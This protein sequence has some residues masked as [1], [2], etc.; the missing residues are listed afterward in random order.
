[1]QAYATTGRLPL[2]DRLRT[3][4]RTLLTSFRDASTAGDSEP[5][6]I[7]QILGRLADL[8]VNRLM[9]R[10]GRIPAITLASGCMPAARPPISASIAT[11]C[12]NRRSAC[13]PQP[14][15]WTALQALLPPR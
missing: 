9:E 7:D 14:P 2:G 15:G 10:T 12:E 1:M 11:R 6:L 5:T 3:L 13:D 4:D 8:V